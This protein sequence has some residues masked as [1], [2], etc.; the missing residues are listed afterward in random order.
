MPITPSSTSGSARTVLRIQSVA[1][2]L[3][4][5]TADVVLDQLAFLAS[6]PATV[7]SRVRGP[8]VG[9][10]RVGVGG[11]G[12]SS[13]VTRR[14]VGQLGELRGAAEPGLVDKAGGRSGSEVAVVVSFFLRSATT[15]TP[16]SDQPRSCEMVWPRRGRRSGARSRI[17]A[18]AGQLGTSSGSSLRRCRFGLADWSEETLTSQRG[19]PFSMSASLTPGCAGSQLA[20]RRGLR[21]PC[22]YRAGDHL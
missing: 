13:R 9:R 7:S 3:A 15:A 10:R 14:R 20:G 4:A 2:G 6:A 22:S 17:R 8:Q 1:V 21:S 12:P 19:W 5:Q 18:P 11:A 16:G